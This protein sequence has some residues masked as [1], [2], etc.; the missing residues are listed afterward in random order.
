MLAVLLR[1]GRAYY[2]IRFDDVKKISS[3]M[4]AE[5]LD[6]LLYPKTVNT[7]RNHFL[8]VYIRYK[9]TYFLSSVWQFMT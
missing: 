1:H 5:M 7:G 9:E 3:K 4:P 8:P 6:I 2:N